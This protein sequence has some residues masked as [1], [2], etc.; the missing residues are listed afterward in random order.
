MTSSDDTAIEVQQITDENSYLMDCVR[1]H[2]AALP[3]TLSSQRG[4][5]PLTSIYQRLIRQ[6]HAVYV[7][8]VNKQVVGG[9][10]VL[11]YGRLIRTAE[12][13]FHQPLMWVRVVKRLGVREFVAQLADLF[14]LQIHKRQLPANDYILALYVSDSIRRAGV[15]RSLVMAARTAAWRRGV[16]LSVDT[17]ANNSVAQKFYRSVG[18]HETTRTKRSIILTSKSE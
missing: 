13:L 1:L 9:I 15:A 16:V 7:A 4:V 11:E 6:G 2:I 8:H 14:S 18:F 3:N 10:V 12:L 5:Q 17:T